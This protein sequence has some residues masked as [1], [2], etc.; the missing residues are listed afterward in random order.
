MMKCG[1]FSL[2]ELLIT[3]TVMALVMTIST[4]SFNS[5][6]RKSGVERQL[7][8]MFTDL[9]ESRVQAFHEKRPYRITFQPSSYVIKNYSTENEPS[10]AGR[11]IINKD[12][13][14]GLTSKN[15]T[16]TDLG[17]DISDKF[18]EFDTRGWS[19][20]NF[21]VIVNPLSAD[22]SVNCLVIS[23]TRVNMGKINGTK[24]EFK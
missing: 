11:I 1:G 15:S 23:D 2:I 10:D 19:S 14:Y 9:S 17:V 3:M 4:L 18:V 8:E 16:G 7:R 24:C 5:W 12:M 21:T 6:T 13:K 22:P 20:N